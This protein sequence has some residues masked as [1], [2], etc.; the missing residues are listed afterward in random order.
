[1][2]PTA[3]SA[4][5]GFFPKAQQPAGAG[6]DPREDTPLVRTATSA[7]ATH[8]SSSSHSSMQPPAPLLAGADPEMAV[9][10]EEGV[11]RLID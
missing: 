5:G 2:T 4:A 9:A 10:F 7:S 1:M 11:W 8:S 6:A 3:S